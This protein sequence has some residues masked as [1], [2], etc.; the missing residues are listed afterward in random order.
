MRYHGPSFALVGLALIMVA[1]VVVVL[2]GSR[3]RW[4]ADERAALR[5]LWLDS[6]PPPPADPSNRVADNPLAAELGRRLFFDV[7]LSSNGR[8]AC[9]TCH[10]PERGFQDN[11]PLGQGVGATDRRTMPLAGVAYSPWLFWDGR[12]DSLWA[13]ALGPLESSVEHGGSRLQYVRQI[14]AHYRAEY[15]ALFGPLPDLSDPSRFPEA[16]GPVADPALRAAWEGMAA[17]DRAAVSAA[18]ANIGKA[19][20][21]YE[22]QLQPSPTRFDAYVAAILAGD[23][24][25][26]EALFSADEAAGLRLYIGEAGCVR[27]HNGPLL[28]NNA[29]HNTG[30][31]APTCVGCH[32]APLDRGRALGASQVQ[33][34]EF[35]CLSP[36]SDAA[37]EQCSALRFLLA[38]DPS[39]ERAFKPPTLR[40]VADR[41]P[42][43]HAGQIASLRAVLLHYNAAPAAPAGRSELAPLGLTAQELD[44][45]EAFL[46]TLS[47]AAP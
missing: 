5:S 12:K 9:A 41:P 38:D 22:R 25:L 19:I 47:P 2:L 44:Q 7:R 6:L 42:Y 14:G 45:L 39:L 18:F 21:A 29:F 32:T 28:T 11:R 31:P 16:G 30:V 4:S 37:P 20:A 26:A 17:A 13:Q 36:Y 43:M 1:A 46:R 35:N 23:N 8:V 27:C 15:E 33:A 10:L 3:E 40:G 34:D 24:R